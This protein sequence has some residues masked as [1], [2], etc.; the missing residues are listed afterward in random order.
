MP[1]VCF[2]RPWSV[3]SFQPPCDPTSL[4]NPGVG[5]GQYI[6]ALFGEAAS[7][8]SK[9]ILA[10]GRYR[11]YL[12]ILPRSNCLNRRARCG[13]CGAS[14]WRRRTGHRGQPWGLAQ[15]IHGSRVTGPG[16]GLLAVGHGLCNENLS[17]EKP[18]L[19]H[20][21][22]RE[23]RVWRRHLNLRRPAVPLSL[24]PAMGFV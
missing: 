23:A 21:Q 5:V 19:H 18:L 14:V 12:H 1:R 17:C 22:K 16:T 24:S 9:E 11:R 4:A 3:E 20:R 2:P 7:P 13:C 6:G 8:V 10:C 15:G